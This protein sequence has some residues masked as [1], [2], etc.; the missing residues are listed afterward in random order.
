M[1]DFLPLGVSKASSVQLILSLLSIIPEGT[2]F[3]FDGKNLPVI[4]SV[5]FRSM[6]R[7]KVGKHCPRLPHMQRCGMPLTWLRRS[8]TGRHL[9]GATDSAVS[10]DSSQPIA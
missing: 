3:V 7:I 8:M 2:A 9:A 10:V 5:S 1:I 6:Y 4:G